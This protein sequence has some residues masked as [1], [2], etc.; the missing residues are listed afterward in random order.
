MAEAPVVIVTRPRREAESWAAGLQT[1]G[2]NTEILPLIDIAPLSSSG[3][4]QQ[5]W[6]L[7][8]QHLAVMFVSANAVRFF[9]AERP[10]G[11]NLEACRAW[12]TGPG[13]QAA[14]LA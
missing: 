10:A 14:L 9:M 5:V 7:V 4:L 8:P 13:T 1:Q 3:G 12:S 6:Q 11:L 2:V